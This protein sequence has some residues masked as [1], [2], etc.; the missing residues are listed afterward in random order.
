MTDVSRKVRVPALPAGLNDIQDLIDDM[1]SLT[2]GIAEHDRHRFESA[3][4]E[5]AANIVEHARPAD[6]RGQVTLDLTVS[7][8]S[9]ELRAVFC[10]DGQAADVDLDDI[11]MPGTHAED[12]RGLALAKTCSDALRYARRGSVNRWT[13]TCRWAEQTPL[14]LSNEGVENAHG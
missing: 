4:V 12:G 10:D 13:I 3:V 2:R 11:T 14:S 5:V 6:D 8:G 1:W 7:F 9:E